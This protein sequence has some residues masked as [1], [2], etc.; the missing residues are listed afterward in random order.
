MATVSSVL[1]ESTTTISSA[2][3]ALS[4][5]AAMWSASLRVMMVTET[6]GTPESYGRAGPFGPAGFTCVGLVLSDGPTPLLLRLGQRGDCRRRD[7][8]A[9]GADRH[10][11]HGFE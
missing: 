6:F 4:I 9:A 5:A 7:A 10:F 2:Q 1:P 8:T 11:L 3:E